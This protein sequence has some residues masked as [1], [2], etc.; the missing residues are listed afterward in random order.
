MWVMMLVV[1]IGLV[2]RLV[3]ELFVGLIEM[4]SVELGVMWL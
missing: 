4:V 2:G 3:G 1:I